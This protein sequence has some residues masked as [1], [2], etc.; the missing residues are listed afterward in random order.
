[1]KLKKI[2]KFLAPWENVRVWGEAEECPLYKGPVEHIPNCILNMKMEK[3]EDS[4]TYMDVRYGCCDCED[5]ISL[6]V[7][8]R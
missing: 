2:L 4:G 1:M 3:S 6:F 8:E 5:H 7:K